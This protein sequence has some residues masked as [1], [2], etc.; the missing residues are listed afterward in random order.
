MDKFIA[1]DTAIIETEI[2]RVD[3]RSTALPGDEVIITDVYNCK[4]GGQIVGIKFNDRRLPMGNIVIL[5]NGV[6]RKKGGDH[7]Q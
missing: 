6:M 4:D 7:G 3:H 1:G 5:G 2:H